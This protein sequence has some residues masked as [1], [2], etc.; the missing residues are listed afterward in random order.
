MA[1]MLIGSFTFGW[2][3]DQVGRKPTLMVSLVFLS[4]GGSLPSFFS[5]NP[6]LYYVFVLSRFIS[7]IGHVGTFMVTVSLALEYVGAD[8]RAT[9]GILIEIP[10]A[11]GGTIV[12]LLSW[13]GMRDWQELMLLVSV[14][15]LLMLVYWFYLPESPR[16]LLTMGRVKEFN[17]VLGEAAHVNKR[18]IQLNTSQPL[19]PDVNDKPT[20]CGGKATFVDL[21][22][23][24]II[25]GRSLCL[26][27]NWCVTILCYFGLTSIAS[28]LT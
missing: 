22:K 27:V 18:Q 23:P 6:D 10:F 17:L 9:F 7:G 24:R 4:F 16:W 12:G 5:L 2:I 19:N 20:D 8:Y 25:L 21:F 26:F 1:G 14:P 13:A 11:L 28:V 3:A 15:N